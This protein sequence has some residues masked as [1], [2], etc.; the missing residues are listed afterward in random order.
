[1]IQFPWGARDSTIV[2]SEEAIVAIVA[3][4]ACRRPETAFPVERRGAW[5]IRRAVPAAQRVLAVTFIAFS[6]SG[7]A[8]AEQDDIENVAQVAQEEIAAAPLLPMG[9]RTQTYPVDAPLVLEYSF[10][11]AATNKVR[12]NV[13]NYPGLTSDLFFF[14]MHVT[15]ETARLAGEEAVRTKG[16]TFMY[17][18]HAS[19]ARDVTV[20]IGGTNYKFDP[21]RIFTANGLE[22]RTE[23]RPRG[24][25]LAELQRF[26][27]WV[28]TNIDLGR[29]QR[30][31]PMVTALHNNSDDDHHGSLL[32]ILTEQALLG[33]DNR[34]VH[35]NPAWDIDDFYIAT[36]RSTYDVLVRHHDPNV[37]LR[38]ER[39]RDIGYLSN[40]MIMEGVEYINVE[41]ESGDRAQNDRMI[42]A[43]Q[44]SFR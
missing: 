22:E 21:N 13:V 27:T 26:V 10:G 35:R 30:A 28:K 8:A 29:A 3:R 37:S 42:S 7:C 19:G 12:L 44:T 15:E 16:G 1:M 24:A 18:T 14:H 40:W 4:R 2:S 34:E 17:L 38:L 36:L 33:A 5:A 43:V 11:G 39:P 31:R 23:P 25:A 32:S 9:Y 6:L 41:T 20:R